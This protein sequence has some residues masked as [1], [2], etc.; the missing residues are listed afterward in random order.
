MTGNTAVRYSG[1]N[2]AQFKPLQSPFSAPYSAE[3]SPGKFG[4]PDMY[5]ST[6][7][8][9]TSDAEM[10]VFEMLPAFARDM[11]SENAWGSLS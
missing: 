7:M 2:S 1:P 3:L 11:T 5:A 6:T 8:A 4:L 10:V 9:R